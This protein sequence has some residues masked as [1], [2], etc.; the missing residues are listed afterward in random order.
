[1]IYI[2]A[3]YNNTHRRLDI[4]LILLL[5]GMFFSQ[6]GFAQTRVQGIVTDLT[7]GIAIEGVTV[8]IPNTNAATATDNKGYYQLSI[9]TSATEIH[10]NALSYIPTSKKLSDETF[11]TVDAELTPRAHLIDEIVIGRRRRYRNR[12]N[13]AVELINQVIAHKKHNSP[14]RFD[15]LSYEIYEKILMA[16][17]EVPQKLVNN[18]LTKGFKF[19]FENTDTTLIPGK[20]VLP[21]Y[22]EENISHQKERMRPRA[23]SNHVVAKRKTELDK[24]YVNNENIET[25]IKFLHT[26]VDVYDN[27]ILVLNRAFL[28]PL[29]DSSPLFYRF[30]LGDTID[31]A[32]G[33]YVELF[34]EPR[35]KEDRLFKGKLQITTDGNYAVRYAELDIGPEANLNWIN[36]IRIALHFDKEPASGIYLLQYSDAVYDFGLASLKQGGYG[37]RTLF[38]HRY[39]SQTEVPEMVFSGQIFQQSPDATLRNDAYWEVARPLPLSDVEAKTYTNLDSLNRNKTFR[40]AMDIGFLLA[41]SYKATGPIEI[42]PV[43]NTYSYNQLEGSRLR[44]SG[45]TSRELSENFYVEGYTA[46]G[47]RDDRW[48]YFVGAGQTLNKRRINEYP[49]HYI[50]VQY[51]YDAREPG[52]DLGFKNGDSFVRSFRTAEQNLWLYHK[53]FKVNHAIEFGNHFMLQTSLTQHTQAPAGTLQ[54]VNGFADSIRQIR[55]AEIGVDLR[56]APF[57]EFMQ[58][59]LDRTPITNQHPIF[60]FRYDIGLKNFLGGQYNYHA[61]RLGIFKRVFLSQLGFADVSAASGYIHGAVPF[62]LLDIPSANQ[63]YIVSRDAFALMHDL[64]FVTDQF[65]KLNIEYRMGGFIFNKIPFFKRLKLREVAGFKMLYGTVSE[66]SRPENNPNLFLLPRT[67]TNVPITH[68]PSRTPYMEGSVGIENILNFLRVEYVKRLSYLDHPD[69]NN[70][71]FRF[72]VHVA[73]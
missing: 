12:D 42:G 59:N 8:S 20:S 55:T 39:D 16:A 69:T 70:G 37:Q 63:T 6:Y 41:T 13:P 21:I 56:W 49:A 54:F 57:E 10:F 61:F 33:K 52:Q 11:Q 36:N 71:G 24:R 58:R 31:I 67:Q 27:N 44:I 64:E 43:E 73:F 18:H 50:H 47:F 25:L 22:L 62:P 4:R 38:F 15:Y 23:S 7:T 1:M 26:D 30:Y 14:D 68:I 28:S 48:K 65:I 60:N 34:Y 45:R 40:T 9:P 72:S 46:Y 51:Q 32:S 35:N 29:A 2:L 19:A 17:A 3:Q 66:N 53:I 5:S